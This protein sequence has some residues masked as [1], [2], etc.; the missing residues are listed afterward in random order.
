MVKKT[1]ILLVL[2]FCSFTLL[3]NGEKSILPNL[4]NSQ[5]PEPEPEPLEKK[6]Q[7]AGTAWEKIRSRSRLKI[8]SGT[9]AGAAKKFAGSPALDFL[10]IFLPC[11]FTLADYLIDLLG[12]YLI[13]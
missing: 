13:A 11:I 2:Y 3:V 8:K 1:I 4:T 6:I 12:M 5:E 9:G 10:P 7:E